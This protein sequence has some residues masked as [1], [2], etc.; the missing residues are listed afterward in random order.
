MDHYKYDEYLSLQ[1][2]NVF[3]E[4]KFKLQL[5]AN[6]PVKKCQIFI[7]PDYTLGFFI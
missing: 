1:I 3:I 4:E 7:G 2:K 5:R 6:V